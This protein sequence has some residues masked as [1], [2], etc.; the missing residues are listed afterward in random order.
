M[1]TYR[2]SLIFPSDSALPRD[3]VTVNPHFE[4]S[5]PEALA[6]ALSTNILTW[7]QLASHPHTV[8][9]YDALKAPPSYPLATRVVAGTPQ[10]SAAPREVALCISYFASYNRPRTRGRLFLPASWLTSVVNVRPSGATMTSALEWALAVLKPG[11]PSNTTWVVYSPTE[12]RSQGRVTDIWCDD[13]WDTVRS[14]GMKATT[15]QSQSF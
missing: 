7:P 11:M 9:I 4:G 8:K 3:A 14:R 13:E 6:Q 1:A 15:R 10:A 2:A 5:D 12:K